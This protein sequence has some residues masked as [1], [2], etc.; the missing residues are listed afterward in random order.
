MSRSFGAIW[1]TTVSPIR[2]SPPVM[3][4]SP[5]IIRSAVELPDPDGPTRIMN[6][7]SL[8]SRSMS[9]TASK[10]SGYRLVTLSRTI[11]DIP[12]PSYLSLTAAGRQTGDDAALEEQHEDD[13][14]DGHD[15]GGRGD[16]PRRGG[17]LRLAGEE[18]QSGRDSAG[19]V[20]GRQRDR[21]QEVVPAENEDQDRGG[22]GPR[23]GERQDHFRERLER[24]RA[25]H[26]CRL[27]EVPGDLAVEGDEHVDRKREREGEV[28]D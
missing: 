10:P 16:V 22:E 27:L 9:R 26:L 2:T 25:V 8:M 18:R 11:S 6:S 21:E 3:S 13:D 4:S 14:G 1:L 20:R 15:D 23:S 5:A 24:R 12:S 7:P 17:E 19:V 28:G